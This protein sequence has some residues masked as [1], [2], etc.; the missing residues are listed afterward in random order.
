MRQGPVDRRRLPEAI[1]DS[2]G[3]RRR[4]R[5]GHGRSARRP[6][7]PP[8]PE[9]PGARVA[10]GRGARQEAALRLRPG[11]RLLCAGHVH[12]RSRLGLRVGAHRAGRGKGCTHPRLRAVRHRL[13]VRSEGGLQQA[14]GCRGDRDQHRKRHGELRR[15]V[16]PGGGHGEQA[17]FPRFARTVER[18]PRQA[19]HRPDGA[20]GAHVPSRAHRPSHPPDQ[21]WVQ[22]RGPLLPEVADS[23]ALA[24]CA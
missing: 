17:R 23:C 4:G 22:E 19:R 16:D 18:G 24:R 3:D 13:P 14:Q 7:C 21:V 20:G 15:Q 5:C 12:Q 8:R 11:A 2:G 6:R 9:G 1:G 10:A